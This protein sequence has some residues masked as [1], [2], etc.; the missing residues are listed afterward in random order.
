M[1]RFFLPESSF[2]DETVRFPVDLARQISSVLRLRPGHKVLAL[3]NAGSQYEVLL[4]VVSGREVIG[5]ALQRRPA[6]GEPAVDVT[7]YLCLTQREKFEW[8][9]QKCTE[10]GASGFVPVISSRSLVQERAEAERKRQRWQRIVREA[11]EQS[12]RGAIPRLS[13]A[14]PLEAAVLLASRAHTAC[15]IPWEKEQEMNLRRALA[16]FR[17]GPAPAEPPP[18]VAILV[19]PEGGFSENEV[20]AARQAGFIPLTLGRRILRMETAAVVAT[21]LVLYELGEMR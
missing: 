4:D 10:V 7:L 17:P 21:A 13:A 18:T 16:P 20:E 6:E 8:T 12:G 9:L 11:A 2:K 3:D 19:G 14:E 1:H 5:R 15:L